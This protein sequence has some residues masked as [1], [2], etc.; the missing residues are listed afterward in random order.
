M[1]GFLF[2]RIVIASSRAPVK[3]ITVGSGRQSVM[4]LQTCMN[5]NAEGVCGMRQPYYVLP[6]QHQDK[7]IEMYDWI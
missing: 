2:L 6:G 1:H 3:K 4:T 5:K 7:D